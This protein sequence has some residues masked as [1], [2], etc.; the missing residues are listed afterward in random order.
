MQLEVTRMPVAKQQYAEQWTRAKRERRRSS[1]LP[2]AR[3]FGAER[4][5]KGE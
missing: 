4:S 3:P 5:C 2:E 1:L